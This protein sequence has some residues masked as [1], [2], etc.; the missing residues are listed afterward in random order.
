MISAR[1]VVLQ[2]P[3]VLT[4][5]CLG[6]L[7]QGIIVQFEERVQ[8]GQ[9]PGIF[10]PYRDLWKLFHKD[11]VSP[12][13]ASWLYFVTPVVAFTCM[14]GSTRRSPRSSARRSSHRVTRCQDT[15]T[16]R[17]PLRARRWVSLSAWR[18]EKPARPGVEQRRSP[19]SEA[20]RL[21]GSRHRATAIDDKTG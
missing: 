8:R 4:V 3:Q 6:L 20:V 13:T 9:G 15:T 12:E 16:R 18:G 5:I 2:V 14:M 21:A 17:A 11:V 19:A 1:D 7:L 10:R